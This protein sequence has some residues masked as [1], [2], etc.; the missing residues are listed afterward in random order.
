M[1]VLLWTAIFLIAWFCLFSLFNAVLGKGLQE[2][3]H[4]IL[5]YNMSVKAMEKEGMTKDEASK[6]IL[7][8]L[9][10]IWDEHYK[11]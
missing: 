4:R 2:S 5:A 11:S 10:E 1:S 6:F 9:D 3:I 8:Y 7:E